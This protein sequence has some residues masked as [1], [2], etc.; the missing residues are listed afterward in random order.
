VTAGHTP[1]RLG[2]VSKIFDVGS[3]IL[4]ATEYELTQSNQFVD[5]PPLIEALDK[6]AQD[7]LEAL[8]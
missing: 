3:M 6:A 8:E 2:L 5:M 4:A 7:V 1:E